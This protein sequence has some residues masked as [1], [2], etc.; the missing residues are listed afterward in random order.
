[1]VEE[2][3]RAELLPGL[4]LKGLEP[5]WIIKEMEFHLP[6]DARFAQNLPG[7][8]IQYEKGVIKG[9]ID[10][11]F[12]HDGKFYL[13]DYKT[14]WLGMGPGDYTPEN[15]RRAMDQHD[16]WL[17]AAIYAAALDTYLKVNMQGYERKLNFGGALYL[18]VRGISEAQAGQNGHGILFISPE[19]LQARYNWVFSPV[20]DEIPRGGQA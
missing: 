20:K 7:H 15:M 5:E 10:L 13:L 11:V 8:E 9:F 12:H 16:Y 2:V 1:M 14:N 6:F 18:F 3:V 17:Q 19:E 4:R